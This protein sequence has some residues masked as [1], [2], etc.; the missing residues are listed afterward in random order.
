[1]RKKDVE[2][3]IDSYV[4]KDDPI[5]VYTG[6]RKL[7]KRQGGVSDDVAEKTAFL[8]QWMYKELKDNHDLADA[9]HKIA[10]ANKVLPKATLMNLT[11][12]V[13]QYR[14]SAG[15][16]VAAPFVDRFA[17]IARANGIQLNECSLSISKVAMDIGGVGVGAVTSI[18]GP[19]G[20]ALLA[21]SVV[22]TFNDSYGLGKACFQ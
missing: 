7:L 1:M 14:L 18:T 13:K 2:E 8:G 17:A 21:L 22:S 3:A 5:N 4:G 20:L 9:L 10:S 11:G 19:V 16:G 12:A 6:L 15:L